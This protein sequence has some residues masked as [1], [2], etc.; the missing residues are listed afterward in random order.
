MDHL[1]ESGL[2]VIS[3]FELRDR[4]DGRCAMVSHRSRCQDGMD[5]R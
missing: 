5:V 2:E 1:F 4:S 3:D